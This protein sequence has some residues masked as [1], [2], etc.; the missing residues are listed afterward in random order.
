MA[1]KILVLNSG[2]SSLKFSLFER[3]AN[4][5]SSV[6]S[7]GVE[8]IGD[9]QNSQLVAHDAGHKSTIKVLPSPETCWACA[10]Q[11]WYTRSAMQAAAEDHGSALSLVVEHLGKLEVAGVGHRVVWLGLLRSSSC[12]PLCQPALAGARQGNFQAPARGC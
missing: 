5:L 8:R 1:S 6:A 12:L 7:G 4:V 11:L 10:L 9:T 2:S 3:A